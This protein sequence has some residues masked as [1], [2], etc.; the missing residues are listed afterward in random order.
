MS[1]QPIVER[2]RWGLGDAA[3]AY[4]AGFVTAT[5]VG[6]AWIG[7]TGQDDVSLGLAVV[8]FLGQWAGLVTVTVLASRRKGTGTLRDDFGL[9]V[10]PRDVVP[11]LVAGVA[12]Q[13]LLLPLLYVPFRLLE[14]DLDLSGEAR[15]VVGLAEGPGLAVLALC[16]VVGAPLAEELF[17]RGLLQRSLARRFGPR[18]AVGLGAVAFGVTHY[19]PVQL[20]GLVAFGVVLGVL[21]ER[22]GRL[23]PALVAHMAFNATT[24]VL[25]AAATPW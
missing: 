22:A 6:A 13:L 7:A 14:P 1:G 8:T 3:A 4:V 5:V 11:G 18:W 12:S 23:G 10:E 2:R 19:Q 20:L 24:V 25:L 17:F 16:I 15:R 21:V 9:A